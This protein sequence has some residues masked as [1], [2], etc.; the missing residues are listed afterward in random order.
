M[1]NGTAI[2]GPSRL[3]NNV[4]SKETKSSRS[5][6]ARGKVANGSYL[7]NNP[8][9]VKQAPTVLPGVSSNIS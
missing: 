3:Y 6:V 4:E 1:V 7:L 5:V 9:V 2:T 8:S